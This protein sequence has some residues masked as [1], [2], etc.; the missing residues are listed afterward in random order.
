[1]SSIVKNLVFILVFASFGS[2]SY[3]EPEIVIDVGTEISFKISQ[4]LNYKE[5]PSGSSFRANMTIDVINKEGDILIDEGATLIGT[6]KDAQK[7]KLV[8]QMEKIK[9]GKK[10]VNIVTSPIEVTMSGAGKAVV[11]GAVV[12]GAIGGVAG[13]K[14]GRRKGAAIGFAANAIGAAA[15]VLTLPKGQV[16]K[17]NFSESLKL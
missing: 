11:R 17:T 1:M 9:I 13:G 3:A 14:K 4:N 8:I 10:Y 16:L 6:V 15:A 5:T 12:G 7:K 2:V